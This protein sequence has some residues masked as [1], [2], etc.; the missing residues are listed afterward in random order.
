[1]T[2]TITQLSRLFNLPASTLRYYEQVGLLTHVQRRGS[3]RLY[4]DG[5]FNRLK[6]ICCFKQAGMT[7]TQLQTYFDL[8]DTPGTEP[9]IVALLTQQERELAAK[10]QAL[11]ESL[12]HLHRKLAFHR[13]CAAAAAAGTPAPCWDHF[14]NCPQAEIEAAL[15]E[16]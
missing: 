11:A 1:M 3:R 15:K 13:A 7:I 12:A 5:H 14:R 16:A 6:S 9:A 2:Y 4:N 8:A 10:Q